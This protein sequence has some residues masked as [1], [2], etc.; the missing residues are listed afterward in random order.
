MGLYGSILYQLLTQKK[1]LFDPVLSNIPRKAVSDGIKTAWEW[2]RL[3]LPIYLKECLLSA[4]DSAPLTLFVDALDECEESSREEMFQFFHDLCQESRSKPNRVRI[5]VSCR[6]YPNVVDVADFEICVDKHNERDIQAYLQQRLGSIGMSHNSE[7]ELKDHIV[8]RAS[9][10]FQWVN[11]VVL[12]IRRMHNDGASLK[13]MLKKVAKTPQ[14][15]DELYTQILATVKDEEVSMTWRL[16]IWV[17]LA[18]RPL[19]LDE[20][21][22]AIILDPEQPFP[23]AKEYRDSDNMCD[24]LEGMERQMRSLSKGLVQ[25]RSQGKEKTAVFVHQSVG[26]FLQRRGLRGLSER[27][28]YKTG[29]EADMTGLAHE[30][31][32]RIC[33]GFLFMEGM[34]HVRYGTT[35]E[36]SH[37]SVV[38]A[39]FLDYAVNSWPI[40]AQYADEHGISQAGLAACFHWPSNERMA[41]W[42]RLYEALNT[43]NS[44]CLPQPIT[45]AR[46]SAE[47]NLYSTLERILTLSSEIGEPIDQQELTLLPSTSNRERRDEL[48]ASRIHR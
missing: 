22:H 3:E 4:L 14:Q 45:L 10:V 5:C 15:L 13:F 42:V 43:T 44:R 23:S 19:T 37:E 39:K 38:P 7:T 1:E 33:L 31:L 26:D 17:C 30:H 11:L 35:D 41:I 46:L 20:L 47:F 48:T 27:M 9:G 25:T 34:H 12:E 16:L 32:C 21:R 40:H 29:I 8:D 24:D 36:Q 2:H 6:P 18:S 28:Q